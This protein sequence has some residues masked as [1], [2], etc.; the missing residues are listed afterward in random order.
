M[1]ENPKN[2]GL[3]LRNALDKKDYS[4]RRLAEITSI[5]K[6]TISRILTGKRKPTLQH[7]KKFSA[8]LELPLNVLV[9]ELD[10]EAKTHSHSPK[11]HAKEN[12]S[13]SRSTS[14]LDFLQKSVLL[15]DQT[16]TIDNIS[17]ELAKCDEYTETVEGVTMVK[18]SFDAKVNHFGNIGPYIQQLKTWHQRFLLAQGTKK[19][20][21]IM[22]GAL[23][24]FILPLDL[25]HDYVFAVGYLDDCLA[26]QLA[27]NRLENKV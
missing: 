17:A 6:A 26:I 8:A 5:D 1:P 24:Y 11:Q 3:L 15:Y 13:G 20:L 27:G 16:V 23:L 21:A 9:E 4:I 18:E 19:E 12:P 14:E 25:L 10:F 7:L 22:G 2:I